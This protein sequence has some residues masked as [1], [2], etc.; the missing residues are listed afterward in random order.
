MK[1]EMLDVAIVGAGPA[2]LACGIE[3]KRRGYGYVILEKGCIVNSIYH[4][5]REM[6]FFTTADLLEIGDVPMIISADKPKRIDGLNYYRRVV[7][8]WDLNVQD[9][10]QVVHIDGA[11]EN[12][13]IVTRPEGVA[14]S[15]SV[16][17]EVR[18]RRVILALGYYDNPNFLGVPGES[19]PKVS[20]YFTEPHPFFRKK[21]AIIGGKNS[22]AEAALQLY[23]SG[24]E[25]TLI[26]RGAALSQAIKYWVLPDIENRIKDNE[27]SA[28][29]NSTVTGIAVDQISV[30]NGASE[31]VLDNDFVFALTGYHPDVDFLGS[32]GILADPGTCRP[33]Y[34]PATLESNVAGIY[35][36]GGMISGKETN[37]IFIEN[38]RFHGAQIFDAPGFCS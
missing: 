20:H 29:F 3:A 2:G 11:K 25:V 38:G 27:I 26:H 5:P 1:E 16:R 30:R 31:R 15:V 35:V 14:A 34:D 33:L 13:R 10:T 12:F 7:D 22:A 6:T 4:Y 32:I 36:A 18:A 28:L 17:A 23:R 21:V 19:L 9:Y 24:A 37:K 8:V